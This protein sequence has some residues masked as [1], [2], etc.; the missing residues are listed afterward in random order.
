MTLHPSLLKIKT[1]LR[2]AFKDD[3]YTICMP[4]F[5]SFAEQV[6]GSEE[7]KVELN[8]IKEHMTARNKSH[9]SF[10]AVAER[11]QAILNAM[12]AIYDGMLAEIEPLPSQAH[13]DHLIDAS[14]AA[15]MLLGSVQ[16][17]EHVHDIFNRWYFLLCPAYYQDCCKTEPTFHNMALKELLKIL[18]L[19]VCAIVPP[20]E[21]LHQNFSGDYTWFKDASSSFELSK[22]ALRDGPNPNSKLCKVFGVSSSWFD[23]LVLEP[24]T[25]HQLSGI[26]VDLDFFHHIMQ[27]TQCFATDRGSFVNNFEGRLFGVFEVF[28]STTVGRLQKQLSASQ[29]TKAKI[30][31]ELQTK[32]FA[33]VQMAAQGF[34]HCLAFLH[35]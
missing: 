22:K 33:G 13:I 32:L 2:A 16:A 24:T 18:G 21:E 19:M 23:P 25:P 4:T 30:L 20:D 6:Q 35:I 8:K 26:D 12:V 15:S 14:R 31:S 3:Q 34:F 17:C 29:S 10:D 1:Q 9:V 28:L 7:L 5:A 27:Y 11:S